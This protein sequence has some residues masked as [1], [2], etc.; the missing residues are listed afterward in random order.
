M[1]DEELRSHLAQDPRSLYEI[2]GEALVE[3]DVLYRFRD[4]KDIRLATAAKL[5]Q[6]L[7]LELTK[8]KGRK[9]REPKRT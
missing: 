7:G 3:P 4:G 9:P 5:A 2:A 8:A 1:I 6:V